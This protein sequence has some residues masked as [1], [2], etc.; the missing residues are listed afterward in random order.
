MLRGCSRLSLVFQ[1]TDIDVR[2][3]I[4][5]SIALQERERG[6]KERESGVM[7]MQPK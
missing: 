5:N 7:Q 6:E 2:P 3:L 1:I 4:L